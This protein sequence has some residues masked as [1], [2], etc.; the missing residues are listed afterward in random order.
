MKGLS[1]LSYELYDERHIPRRMRRPYTGA[2]FAKGKW[3]DRPDHDKYYPDIAVPLE[4]SSNKVQIG[5]NRNQSVWVDIYIPKDAP[6]GVYQGNVFLSHLGA[7]AQAN[8]HR[9][10]SEI[11]RA[12]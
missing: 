8:S 4:L 3:T 2:G 7:D 5:P 11:V 10:K 6:A 9:I 12:S 1:R